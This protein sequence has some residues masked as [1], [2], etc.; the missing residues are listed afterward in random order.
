M[1]TVTADALNSRDK[2][3]RSQ[4]QTNSSKNPGKQKVKKNALKSQ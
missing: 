1:Q 3:K 4:L 2:H